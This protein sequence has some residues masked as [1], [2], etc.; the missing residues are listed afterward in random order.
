MKK[1]FAII[2]SM[3][4]IACF[5]P[6]MAFAADTTASTADDLTS[7]VNSASSG[8]TIKLSSS[9]TLTAPLTIGKGKK[10]TLDLGEYTLTNADGQHTIVIEKGGTLTIKGK[11]TVD[12]VSNGKAALYNKGTAVLSGG[13][14]KRSQEAG[15]KD[16]K[17]N[18]NSWYT[19]KNIGTMTIEDG[20]TVENSGSHSSMIANG[21][22]TG[23]TK[24]GE[25]SGSDNPALTINGG[26]FDGGLNTVKNDDRAS[27]IINGGTFKNTAQACIQNH[28][29]AVINGGTFSPEGVEA[30]VNCGV[31]S[32]DSD[33]A[34]H[35]LTINDGTFNGGVSKTQG[36]VTIRGG[37]FSADPKSYVDTGKYD[38]TEGEN[39]WY[40]RGTEAV[41]VIHSGT[42]TEYDA[43]DNAIAAAQDGDTIKLTKDVIVDPT[44]YNVNRCLN[45][46]KQ[47]ISIDLNGK[48]LKVPNCALT[49]TGNGVTLKN[50]KMV[51]TTTSASQTDGSYVAQIKGKNAVVTGLTTT[52]GINVSGY[53]TETTNT[54][55]ATVT[56][57]NCTIQA[58]NYYTVC[59]Q[60][61]SEVTVKSSTL[62]YGNYGYFWIEKKD[63]SEG[64][65]VPASVS[66]KLSYEKS[67]VTFDKEIDGTNK[68]YNTGGAAPVAFCT[69]TIN[70][71]NGAAAETKIVTADSTL[72]L[73]NPK[74]QG[75]TFDGW[76]T[77]ENGEKTWSSGN[78]VTQNIALT[79]KWTK[80]ASEDES[81]SKATTQT[82]TKTETKKEN[83]TTTT[84][85][86]ET[87]TKTDESGNE[88]SKTVTEDKTVTTDDK[89]VTTTTTTV[90][91]G[92]TTTETKKE[93]TVDTKTNAT[94]TVESK[95]VVTKDEDGNETQNT[96]EKVTNIDAAGNETG[97]TETTSKATK[98][99]QV[100]STEQTVITKNSE[101][102]ETG[103]VTT[104][105]VADTVNNV[106]TTTSVSGSTATAT[107]EIS[108]QEDTTVTT[109]TVTLDATAAKVDA[110]KVTAAEVTLPAATVTK[111]NTAATNTGEAA[112]T[113]DEV[114][115]KTDVATLSI[116]NAALKTLTGGETKESDKS[117]VLKVEKTDSTVKPNTNAQATFELSAVLK[118][119]NTE[120]PV[121][122]ETNKDSNGT[123]AVSVSYTKKYARSYLTVY[124]VKEGKRVDSMPATY[125][126]DVLTWTT[127]HFSTFEVVET[128]RSSS[129]GYVAPST[130]DTKKDDTATDTKT[131]EEVQAENAAKAASLTKAL[132]LKARSVKTTRGNIKVTLTVDGDAIKAIEDLGYTVKYR[133]YRSTKKAASYKA[134]LE[135]ADKTYTNTTGKKGTKYYYKARVMVYDAQGE[136]VTK[137]ELK[138][139]RYACRIK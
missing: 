111:L 90:T 84:T 20:V 68:L 6:S 27:M 35:T 71:L 93:T 5:M 119:E 76:Y 29:I 115:V 38:V 134:A 97:T 92:K 4:M 75:Y 133:F 44:E 49:I 110:D 50:G 22:Y 128:E 123:I 106:T 70:R 23:G 113:V 135:K 139:C 138:Q 12:N 30:V 125:G 118:N 87:E 101:G 46:T 15:T 120:T 103:T 65:G 104:K 88:I 74:R 31:C 137:S 98:V 72:T 132:T 86:T 117:L 43:L 10:I 60:Q 39:N 91:E 126:D 13:I 8:D 89:T 62:K 129:G 61:N 25:T 107:A 66:S 34:K 96:T 40:V 114:K 19:I 100:T 24:D 112:A 9:I 64:E 85:A 108:D 57:T 59:A 18:G 47:N 130:D 7:A 69:V 14:F 77:N 45:V 131:D 54:P 33:W 67:T 26:T 48:T 105:N 21:Y 81:D 3:L 55:D 42:E 102:K 63:Y 78:Q 17:A 73:D 28:N 37:T 116:D 122:G 36:T 2:M 16:G 56:V 1:I 109:S 53:N 79:A 121:F 127:N 80:N 99:G 32:A 95:T 41:K 136:L 58:T 52:G 11:G 124:Y 51:S 83:G 94:T 82:T